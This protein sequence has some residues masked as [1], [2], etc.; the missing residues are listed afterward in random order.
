[1]HRGLGVT[2]VRSQVYISRNF[3]Q[4][5]ENTVIDPCINEVDRLIIANRLGYPA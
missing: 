3:E 1:M 4:V 2:S 5:G